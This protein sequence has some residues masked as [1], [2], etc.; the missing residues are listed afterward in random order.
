MFLML[1][2][3][4]GAFDSSS[5]CLAT[6][7]HAHRVEVSGVVPSAPRHVLV[8]RST[9]VSVRVFCAVVAVFAPLTAF[10]I[11]VALS[12][13]ACILAIAA[14]FAQAFGVGHCDYLAVFRVGEVLAVARVQFEA[15][16]AYTA[17]GSGGG[18]FDSA[19]WSAVRHRSDTV[20]VGGGFLG[21]RAGVFQ[22]H[23]LCCRQIETRVA[24]QTLLTGLRAAVGDARSWAAEAHG[25]QF[26]LGDD[27][28]PGGALDLLAGLQNP[29]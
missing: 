27:V 24:L 11:G 2:E 17:D 20:P 8:V 4:L 28:D 15:W 3:C 21:G 26:V 14:D 10:F 22:T 25:V 18:C 1:F 29:T 12:V 23:V 6:A 9:V 5:C 7:T 19:A 16:F 13:R